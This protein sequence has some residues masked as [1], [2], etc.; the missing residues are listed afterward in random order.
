[1]TSGKFDQFK[2]NIPLSAPL[3]AYRGLISQL[4]TESQERLQYWKKIFLNALRNNAQIIIDAIPELEL[5]ILIGLGKHFLLL[6]L[7]S[8][9]I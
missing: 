6:N 2:R 4:L 1:M 3:Q 5:I 8:H 7:K 9:S